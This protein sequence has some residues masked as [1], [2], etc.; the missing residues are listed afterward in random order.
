MKLLN[1]V[2]IVL[3]ATTHP[4]N[5]GAAARAMKTMGL[6]RLY[7]VAPRYFP[8]EEATAM[9]A[10][11]DDLLAKA[12]V[13][14]SLEAAIA[15][16]KLVIGTSARSRTLPWPMLSP[17]A[18]GEKIIAEAA[19]GE[20]ALVFGQERSGLSNEEL[21]L[22]HY[23]VQIPCDSEFS[24]L[25]VAAAVQILSYEIRMAALSKTLHLPE[26]VTIEYASSEEAEYFYKH[27]EE[28]LAHIGFLKP[29]NATILMQRFR[30]LYQRARLEKI[31][32]S[33]LRGLL[34]AIKKGASDV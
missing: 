19:Q 33:M 24:S 6:G 31:E 5:I 27:L 34:T 25:N 9:A 21:A 7:L 8:H 26:D 30:R 16:C 13:C 15:D 23:H 4:G 10:G 20:V 22:C 11:A 1:Q 29:A 32:V 3:V 14:D 17:K 28:T 18:S 12:V 2:R